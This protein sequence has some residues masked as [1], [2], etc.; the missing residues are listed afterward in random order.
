MFFYLA[1]LTGFLLQPSVLL[2][3]GLAIASVL[4]ARGAY[5]TARWYLAAVLALALA[6]A[7]P[8]PNVMILPLEQRFSR[9]DLAGPPI[10]GLIILGGGEDARLSSQRNAHALNEAGERITEAL[11]LARK[12]PLSQVVFTGGSSA[13]LDG[14]PREAEAA[15]AMLV[16]LGL[17]SDRLTL[18]DRSRDTWENAVFTRAIVNPKPGER[19]LLITSAW[20]MPRAMGVFRAADMAV[21]PWPVDYRTGGWGDTLK[22]F[23]SPADGLRRF[24]LITKEYGGL[25]AYWMKG[26]STSLFPAPCKEARTCK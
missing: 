14:A 11:A 25:L 18:E 1:K 2:I 3:V 9:A 17:S 12:L 24:D 20:H 7:S 13:L 16:S 10:T 15:R 21:E 19:W 4:L 8:L 6:A 26:R 22:F 23:Q 5:R